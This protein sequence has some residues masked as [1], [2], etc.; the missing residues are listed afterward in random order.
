MCLKH[1]LL[2]PVINTTHTPPNTTFSPPQ[3]FPHIQPQCQ[4]TYQ[5]FSWPTSTSTPL[6]PD[7]RNPVTPKI[8]QHKSLTLE[9]PIYNGEGNILGWLRQV[10]QVLVYHEVQFTEW[11]QVCTFYLRDEVLQWFN[12]YLTNVDDASLWPV[13]HSEI[14][15]RFGPPEMIRP[16]ESLANLKQITSVGEY[17]SKF[18]QLAGLLDKLQPSY[19]VDKY[20]KGLK[21]DIKFEVLAARSQSFKDAFSL[22][23]TFEEKYFLRK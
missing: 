13:F 22:T 5:P 2:T 6:P 8:C 9:F 1:Q 15:T 21:D 12:W 16:F 7:P 23:K 10:E 18:E 3:A 20:I 11:V 14:R 4:Y 17:L 19:R